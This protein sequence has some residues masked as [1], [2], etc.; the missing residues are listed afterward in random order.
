MTSRLLISEAVREALG[1]ACDDAV[2]LGAVP[3]KGYDE[4]QIVWK[5]G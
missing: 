3:I 2:S 4:P 1:E 5:L